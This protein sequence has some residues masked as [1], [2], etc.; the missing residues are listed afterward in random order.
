[1]D[2]RHL[3]EQG[4]RAAET[5][6]VR[7]GAKIL[8]R[9]M[10]CPL[11]EIDLIARMDGFLCFIEVKSRSSGAF[12][13]PAG[14]VGRTKRAHIVRAAQWYLKAKGLTDAR[15]RFDVVEVL[16]QGIRHLPGAFSEKEP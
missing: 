8:Q 6:L 2:N 11:G 9:N 3:G 12:G 15:V 16:P 5:F 1:M 13:P 4:E 14:A 7:R 10:R